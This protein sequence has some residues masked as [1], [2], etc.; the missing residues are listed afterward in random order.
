MNI[1]LNVKCKIFPKA[2]TCWRGNKTQKMK[3]NFFSLFYFSL[4]SSGEGRSMLID[5]FL[6]WINKKKSLS[7]AFWV[8]LNKRVDE[9]TWTEPSSF[10]FPGQREKKNEMRAA[11]GS[12]LQRVLR[13]F[14]YSLHSPL[15]V[16]YYSRVQWRML[17]LDE[18]GLLCARRVGGGYITYVCFFF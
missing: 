15:L 4:F 3:K 6:L 10:L 5:W 11:R 13:T 14:F 17:L 18:A 16:H 8:E 2:A 1:H 12:P 7:I 9:W